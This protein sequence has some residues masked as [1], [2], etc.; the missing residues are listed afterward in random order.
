MLALRQRV[1][2]SATNEAG[3]KIETP[4]LSELGPQASVKE[5][6][7][8]SDPVITV[9][10]LRRA[11]KSTSNPLAASVL[12]S[13]LEAIVPSKHKRTQAFVT[14]TSSGIQQITVHTSKLEPIFPYGSDAGPDVRVSR[15]IIFDVYAR[16]VATPEREKWLREKA[17]LD[18]EQLAEFAKIDLDNKLLL[19]G[20]EAFVADM[21][22]DFGPL[23]KGVAQ[24]I[25]LQYQVQK[26]RLIELN[27]RTRAAM[28]KQ[29]FELQ[30]ESN[31]TK[32]FQLVGTWV[33]SYTGHHTIRLEPCEVSAQEFVL[34]ASSIAFD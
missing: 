25:K 5:A 17:S 34:S 20:F 4:R 33:H 12:E 7:H 28:G 3:K 11:A 2:K 10:T 31:C 9:E 30:M 23:E 15:P 22:Y 19:L 27:E 21:N 24:Q 13:I 26:Q 14:F 1:Y 8:N 29:E 32:R 18:A 16:V 6:E